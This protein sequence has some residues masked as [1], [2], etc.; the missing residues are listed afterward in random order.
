MTSQTSSSC[1]GLGPMAHAGARLW[2]SCRRVDIRSRPPSS[3][4]RPWRQDGPTVVVGHSYGGQVIT[5]LGEDAPN[6]VALVYIAAFGL[7]EGET[8]AGI[9]A[10]YP[11]TAALAH[12]DIDELGF[13]WLPEDDY[14]THFA[15]DVDPVRARVLHASQQA[16]AASTL[17]DVMGTPAWKSLP[18]WFM[19]AENDEA[20]PPNAERLFAARMG[21]TT[22]EIASSHV[23]MLSHPDE[24]V[25]LTEAAAASL[26]VRN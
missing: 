24:V 1:T 26:L 22:V 20:I 6:A 10:Q 12:L 15:S 21:A 23:A 13:A 9:F 19:V 14:V 3:P 17:G 25:R 11:P 8:I 7:D 2:R 16:L 5:A 4:S 18:T